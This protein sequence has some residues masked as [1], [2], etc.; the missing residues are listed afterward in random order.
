[1]EGHVRTAKTSKHARM[2]HCLEG[3]EGKTNEGRKMKPSEQGVLTF[4]RP[5]RE[6]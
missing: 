3:A 4:W 1:M 6:G 5:Q 2:T